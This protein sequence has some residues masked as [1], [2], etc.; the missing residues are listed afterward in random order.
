[1]R[2]N[3]THAASCQLCGDTKCLTQRGIAAVYLL[4]WKSSLVLIVGGIA[5]AMLYSAYGLL[6]SL[7]G[8]V[9]PLANADLRLFLYPFVALASLCGKKANCPKCEP[10]CS[11]FRQGG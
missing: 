6:I 11:I 9:L 8:Y 2:C 10:A 7:L 3:Q 1:M 5:V 4:S